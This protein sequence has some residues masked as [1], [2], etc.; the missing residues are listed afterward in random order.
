MNRLTRSLVAGA[1]ALTTAAAA[2]PLAMAAGGGGDGVDQSDDNVVI[3]VNTTDGDLAFEFS[4]SLRREADGVVD[5]VNVAAALASCMD[6]S[7]VALALQGVLVTRDADDL[8]PQNIAVAVNDQCSG[9]FTYAS[10]SQYVFG[11]SGPVRITRDGRLRLHELRDF[12]EELEDRAGQLTPTGLIAAANAAEAELLA[13]LTEEVVATGRPAPPELPLAP[14]DV[15]PATTPSPAT[16]TF[17]EPAPTSSST[18][19]PATEV[20]TDTTATTA[21]PTSVPQMTPTTVESATTAPPSSTPEASTTA[22][23]DTATGDPAAP[24]PETAPPEA[25]TTETSSVESS[26]PT[27]P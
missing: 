12:L 2:A 13:I 15:Q 10:A 6:C 18:S 16:T 23:M 22:P 11:F 20:P 3:V 26:P 7:T 25:V 21:E 1:I 8:T 19:A 27:E 9:C 14:T 5:N 24:A 17:E 4:F